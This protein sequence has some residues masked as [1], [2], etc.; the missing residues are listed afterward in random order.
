MPTFDTVAGSLRQ[1]EDVMDE[2]LY[3]KILGY[4]PM[5]RSLTPRELEAVVAVSRLIRVKQE[6][7]LIREGDSASAMYVLVEGKVRVF[8]Q[9][10]NGEKTVL[11]DLAAPSVFGEM[12]LIDRSPRSASVGTLSDAIL[13]QVDLEGFNRLRASYHAG[14]YKVLRELAVTLCK[15]VRGTGERIG[16]FL[17]DPRQ[18]ADELDIEFRGTSE[19]SE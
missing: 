15:R 5:F 6:T 8:K 17:E 13:Y 12:A 10:A 2:G 18:A 9:L 11:A 16:R 4:V 3:K 19:L 1:G 7:V 14:A